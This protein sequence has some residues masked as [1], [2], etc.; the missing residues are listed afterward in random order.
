VFAHPVMSVD[1][2]H[3]KSQ[4]KWML[5][6]ASVLTGMDNVYPVEFAVTESNEDF[7]GWQWFL[8]NL[9]ECLQCLSRVP[10]GKTRPKFS[11]VS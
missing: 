2:C 6:T 5:Y 9:K 1:A 8:C 3:L 10:S 4:W 7:K 11:F